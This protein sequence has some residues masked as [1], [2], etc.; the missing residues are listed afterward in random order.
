[1]KNKRPE[2]LI[3]F[4][5]GS[6]GEFLMLLNICQF[7]KNS[8]PD[9]KAI[10]FCT[11]SL[12]FL[13]EISSQYDF[14]EIRSLDLSSLFSVVFKKGIRN[15]AILSP[16]TF[17]DM[18]RKIIFT[19]KLLGFFTS[20]T[21]LG[22]S[23]L[24]YGDNIKKS[25][26]SYDLSIDFDLNKMFYKNVLDLLKKAEF[27]FN[28]TNLSYNYRKNYPKNLRDN[29]IVVHIM[30]SNEKR[31]LPIYRWRNI[32]S[33][34]VENGI[35]VYLTGSKTDSESISVLSSEINGVYNLA[36]LLS[37]DELA[38]LIEG[39]RAFVGVDTGITHLAGVLGVS[40]VIIGNNSNPT[41]LPY[42]NKKLKVMTN[43]ERC[44]C[45]K[46][47][48]G[49]CLVEVSGKKY[50]KCMYDLKDDDIVSEIKNIYEKNIVNHK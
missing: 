1:M 11:K 12:D 35:P 34:L 33:R 7:I 15:S 10:I 45:N 22:F 13:K 49:N 25:D 28:E 32:I 17:G 44:T 5:F 4:S 18:P 36:G 29:Y 16:F 23:G 37:F 39:S 3:A 42:Y 27:S 26:I 31:S 24:N 14:V 19:E 47:K 2:K 9:F 43:N 50:L 46:D 6:I 40:G 21:V 38:S 8:N 20:S 30:A 41:W 48:K